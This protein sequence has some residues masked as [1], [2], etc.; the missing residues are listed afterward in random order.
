MQF[1]RTSPFLLKR[2]SRRPTARRIERMGNDSRLGLV[3][4]LAIVL[5]VAVT[6]YPKMNG[7]SQPQ[8]NVVPSLPSATPPR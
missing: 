5:A 1:D 6:Y 3:I 7:T 2:G 4:G 8:A